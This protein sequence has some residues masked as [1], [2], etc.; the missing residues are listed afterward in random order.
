MM[1]KGDVKRNEDVSGYCLEHQTERLSLYCVDKGCGKI[2]CPQCLL[3]K[4][5]NV[6]HLIEYAKEAKGR[7]KDYQGVSKKR[8]EDISKLKSR[9]E[10]NER[11]FLSSK[12]TVVE[13][14]TKFFGDLEKMIEETKNETIKSFESIWKEKEK[15]RK[16]HIEHLK[17]EH[18]ICQKTTNLID[19]A[20]H[21]DDHLMISK[22]S[23]LIER[24]IQMWGNDIFSMNTLKMDFDLSFDFER[25]KKTLQDSIQMKLKETTTPSSTIPNQNQKIGLWKG[26][27]TFVYTFGSYGKNPGQ[28]NIPFAVA[29]DQQGNIVVTDQNNHRIQIF[30]PN[31]S[32][33]KQFGSLGQGNG[34]FNTPQGL[35]IDS[36]GNI[37]V[38]DYGNNRIQFFDKNGSFL[39]S[40]SK[41]SDSTPFNK[42]IDIT[43]DHQG[44]LVVLE[45]GNA[46]IRILKEDG[47]LIRIIGSKGNSDGQLDN[48]FGIA[49]DNES[50]FIVTD[51]GNKRIQKFSY[52]GTF[53]WK[54][55]VN[56]PA[57]IKVD[58][59]GKIIFAQYSQDQIQVLNPDGSE[60]CVFGSRG[61][62]NGQFL[63]PNSLCIDSQGRI[64]VCDIVNH[65]I[66][67]FS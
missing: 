2:L 28:F 24:Y 13:R 22:I 19:K 23:T 6:V 48:P 63:T 42:P 14:V 55:D 59:S 58:K 44:N 37:I 40:I 35:T 46:Q 21:S 49:I 16:K 20:L 50:N 52:N 64:L 54:K 1:K 56:R 12:R 60:I 57:G 9:E 62:G 65:R 67:I 39:K 3:G 26:T 25:F 51:Y 38:V 29:V 8:V 33:L 36:S 10:D 5:H 66:Q 47:S 27:G 15:Q 4:K 11:E 34:Q 30:S 7:L 18:F 32:F 41:T 61:S 53:L 45:Y 31:G 43:I 17:T